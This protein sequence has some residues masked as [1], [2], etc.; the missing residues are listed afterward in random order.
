MI[1]KFRCSKC[2]STKVFQHISI[3]A[4]QKMNVKGV[5]YEIGHGGLYNIFELGDG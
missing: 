4:K 3:G 5:I 2:N 1:K